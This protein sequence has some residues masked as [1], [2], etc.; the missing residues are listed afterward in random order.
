MSPMGEAQNSKGETV[1][2]RLDTPN[3]YILT[4]RTAS[5]IAQ[6]ILRGDYKAGY[7]TPC[8]IYGNDLIVLAGGKYH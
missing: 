3:G 5:I 1:E 7:A 4:A 6:N 8:M 2:M